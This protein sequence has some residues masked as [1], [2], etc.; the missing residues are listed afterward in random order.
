MIAG[1]RPIR[2][3]SAASGL[4]GP[5]AAY[6]IFA[7]VPIFWTLKIS[8]TPERLLYSRRHHIV[9]VADDVP[10][11]RHG[12][13]GSDFPNAYFLKQRH[14]FRVDG[15]FCP[16]IA[17][18]RLRHVA[19]HFPRQGRHWRPASA[20][21][22]LPLVMVIPPIYRIMTARPHQQPARTDHHL[23]RFN[24]PS[25]PSDAILLRRHSEDLEEAAMIDG[26]HAAPRAMRKVDRPLR[27]R[28]GRDRSASSS[29]P[30][31]ASS[32]A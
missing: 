9:A 22:D 27:C 2:A 25:P 11:F 10:E 3:S 6:M 21:P 16:V 13:G 12:A 14:R 26:L 15:G 18:P 19:L 30:P 32:F 1:P 24:T 17:T 5:S 28:H 7:A 4:Y 8:V 31:G 23:T 29:P 20:Y